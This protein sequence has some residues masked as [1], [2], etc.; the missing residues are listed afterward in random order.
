MNYPWGSDQNP[1]VIGDKITFVFLPNHRVELDEAQREYPG[2]ALYEERNMDG[3]LLYWLYE[4]T[5]EFHDS[6]R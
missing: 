3:E 5:D 4:Y 1:P 2:G 6:L